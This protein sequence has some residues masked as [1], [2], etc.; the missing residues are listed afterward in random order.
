ML[1]Y[2]A[3]RL[4]LAVLVLL[5]ISILSFGLLKSSG[6]LAV[7]LGGEGAG[8][9]YAAFLRKEYGWDQPLYIQYARWLGN[10]LTGDFGKSYYYHQSVT[11]LLA[12]RLPTTLSLGALAIL[13]ALVVSIPLGVLA[14]LYEGR[15]ADRLILLFALTGQATPIF[16]F[17][18]VLMLVLGIKLALLPIS[19]SGTILHLVMPALALAFNATPALT[20]IVRTGMLDALGSDYVRTARAKGLRAVTV[21]VKHALRNALVPV[22]AVST[23]QFGFLLGGSVIVETI[24]ALDGVGYFTWQAISQNDYPIVQATL[25]IISVFYVVL[26]LLADFLNMLIDPRIRLE[27]PA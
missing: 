9:D 3:R 13:I 11:E 15:W 1:P 17:A 24:F 16:W 20:R 26:T 8:A 5:T 12:S 25:L 21:V 27:A 6:D 2:V 14:A 4:G 10:A 7:S 18:F 19:G 22:V 23:V